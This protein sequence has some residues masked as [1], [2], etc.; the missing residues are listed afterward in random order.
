MKW[1][2]KR[3]LRLSS[4][5]EIEESGPAPETKL[6][7]RNPFRCLVGRARNLAQVGKISAKVR[8]AARIIVAT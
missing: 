6:R 5:A 3:E 7:Y 4:N 2:A 8:A 1:R